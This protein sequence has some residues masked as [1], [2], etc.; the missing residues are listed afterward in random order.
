MIFL[1]LDKF[2]LIDGHSLTHL[3]LLNAFVPGK[4]NDGAV[5]VKI[6]LILNFSRISS[7]SLLSKHGFSFSQYSFLPNEFS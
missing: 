2:C 5:L 7:S 6:Q 4:E 3:L 1:S